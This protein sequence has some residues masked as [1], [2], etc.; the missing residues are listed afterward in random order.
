LE[1]GYD[2]VTSFCR[3]NPV[4]IPHFPEAD[5]ELIR[6]LKSSSDVELILG[7]RQNPDRAKFFAAFFCRYSSVTYSI[8][9][10]VSTSQIQVDYI[11]ARAWQY[12]FDRLPQIPAEN[13]DSTVWQNWVVDITGEFLDQFKV[14]SLADIHYR[15]AALPPPMLCYVERSLNMMPALSR[16]VFVMDNHWHWPLSRIAS[17]L[18][19]EGE[20]VDD[21]DLPMYLAES[22]QAFEKNLPIDLLELYPPPTATDFDINT[23]GDIVEKSSIESK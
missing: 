12:I 20:Q 17:H 8:V 3:C 4:Q 7:C 19:A 14:P 6:P 9:Q 1:I 16:L 22:Q 11:F 10:H 21:A 23:A 15:L 2:D 5:H 18:K 13:L